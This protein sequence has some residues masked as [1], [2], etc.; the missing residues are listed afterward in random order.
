[1]AAISNMVGLREES[2]T[3]LIIC[4]SCSDIPAF[5]FMAAGIM[6]GLPGK[7]AMIVNGVFGNY[8]GWLQCDGDS[9]TFAEFDAEDGSCRLTGVEKAWHRLLPCCPRGYHEVG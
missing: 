8:E 5:G 7:D 1:M 2:H 6:P 3:A 9:V 4:C